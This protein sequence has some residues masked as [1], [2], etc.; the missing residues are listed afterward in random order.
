MSASLFPGSRSKAAT[1]S[2][3]SIARR[4]NH[5]VAAEHLVLDQG[6]SAGHPAPSRCWC[7]TGSAWSSCPLPRRP[8][9]GS[10]S[11]GDIRYSPRIDKNYIDYSMTRSGL[12]VKCLSNWLLWSCSQDALGR[13]VQLL[14]AAQGDPVR[15]LS[16]SRPRPH[17]LPGRYPAAALS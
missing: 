10:Q 16:G 4:Y 9:C 8:V 14:G 7:S 1:T 3:S 5:R 6:V 2:R 13:L 12:P 17:P 15:H 11:S